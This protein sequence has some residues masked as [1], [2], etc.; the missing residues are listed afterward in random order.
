MK[1]SL[2]LI[3][4]FLG[5]YEDLDPV[6]QLYD[7]GGERSGMLYGFL[8]M[9]V[10]AILGAAHFYLI[11]TKNDANRAEFK[12]W[13]KWWAYS[14]IA[15]FIIEELVL[16]GIFTVAGEGT[17]S[18]FV[19]LF[20][21]NGKLVLFSLANAVYSLFPYFLIS[22]FVFKRISKNARFIPCKK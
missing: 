17:S 5:Q 12:N 11:Y 22:F 2:E 19:N 20:A 1:D 18:Y 4:C 9:L 3:Y 16:A 14:A 15:I 7:A 13:W 10:I 6:W 8:I 21:D